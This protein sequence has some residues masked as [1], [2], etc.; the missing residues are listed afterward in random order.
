MPNILLFLIDAT[1]YF[2]LAAL[3]WPGGKVCC[4]PAMWHRLLAL[5]PLLLHI[6]LLQ[7]TV[8]PA[9]GG[10]SLGFATSFSAMAALTVFFYA[11][12]S[13]HYPLGGLQGFVLAFGGFALVLH[14]GLP[15]ARPMA[16]GA[17]P[18]FVLH[19]LVA[20]AAYGFFTIASLHAG[21]IWLAEKYLHRPV[22]PKLVADLPPLLT[23][24]KLLFRMIEAGF[25]LLT[26]TLITGF[27][28]AEAIFGYPLP[29]N[30]M[31]VFGLL[32][33]LIYFALLVGRRRYGWRGRHAIHWAVAGFVLLMLSYFGVSFVHEI[34][35]GRGA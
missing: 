22:P 16:H 17:D 32:S 4:R 25:L 31:T 19:L 3:F 30:H 27:L 28:F 20:F 24:E 33:W 6:Y 12:A 14:A 1:L 13:W 9:A 35:L 8:L 26:L 10:V 5:L 29:W 23:L 2:V 21:L 11:L 34:I 7:A 18:L 15:A